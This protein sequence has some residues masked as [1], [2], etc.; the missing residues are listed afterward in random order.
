MLMNKTSTGLRSCKRKNKN[1]GTKTK[2]KDSGVYVP[3]CLCVFACVCV[4]VCVETLVALFHSGAFWNPQR[5]TF[6]WAPATGGPLAHVN[7]A[8]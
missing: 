3:V 4:F 2:H 7:R 1:K 5:L 8:V 6:H